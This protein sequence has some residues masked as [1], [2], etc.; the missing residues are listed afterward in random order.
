MKES[1]VSCHSN[2]AWILWKV[3][4][5]GGLS[6][7]G[8]LGKLLEVLLDGGVVDVVLENGRLPGVYRSPKV[9]QF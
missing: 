6:E 1:S 5:V 4:N 8:K 3:G 2:V 7:S 9:W